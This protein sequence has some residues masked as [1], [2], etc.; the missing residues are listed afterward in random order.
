MH[1]YDLAPFRSATKAGNLHTHPLKLSYLV[2]HEADQGA[3]D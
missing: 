3:D 2:N 1:I